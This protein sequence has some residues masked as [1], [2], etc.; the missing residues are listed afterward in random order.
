MFSKGTMKKIICIQD[1]LLKNRFKSFNHHVIRIKQK[2]I[3]IE[4]KYW[5]VCVTWHTK[6]SIF[7]I[8][9]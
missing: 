8:F 7:L 6:L 4:I 3:L 1:F 5:D 2:N 9:Y